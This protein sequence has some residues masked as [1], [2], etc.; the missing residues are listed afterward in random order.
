VVDLDMDLDLSREHTDLA[1]EL[2]LAARPARI[3]A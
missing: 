2:L 1:D 3:A